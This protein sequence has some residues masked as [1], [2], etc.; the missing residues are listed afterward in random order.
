MA[1]AAQLWGYCLW[2][3]VLGHYKT[4]GL[5]ENNLFCPM[6]PD[7]GPNGFDDSRFKSV[8]IF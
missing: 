8:C 3:I 5:L 4:T 6:W 1:L 2:K 7:G